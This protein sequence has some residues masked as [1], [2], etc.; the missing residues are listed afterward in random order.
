METFG[1]VDILQKRLQASL[2]PLVGLLLV[3]IH[4]FPLNG[5]LR[6]DLANAFS[7]GWPGIDMTFAGP[8]IEQALHIDM[9]TVLSSPVRVMN[10]P[11]GDGR[12]EPMPSQA[13]CSGNCAS[14]RRE[15]RQPIHVREE[16]SRMQAKYTKPSGKRTYV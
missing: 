3:Q 10:Q 16:I 2:G 8:D 11:G 12:V 9:A 1:V 13:A 5:L 7:V 15:R 4:F 14:M 6:S